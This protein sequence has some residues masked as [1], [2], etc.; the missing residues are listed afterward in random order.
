M[1]ADIVLRILREALLLI[2]MLSAPVMLATMLVGLIV[3]LLQATT[4][5]QEQ[6]LSYVP[7]LVAAFV[8]LALTAPWILQHAV[9][10]TSAL[11]DSIA[12]VR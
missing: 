3:G 6:T 5:L 11:L 12:A 7:K 10:F 9:R 4:Q 8:T 1:T 2:L